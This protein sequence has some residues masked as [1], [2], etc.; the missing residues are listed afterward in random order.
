MAIDKLKIANS[1]GARVIGRIPETGP[2]AFSAIRVLRLT[3]ELRERLRP[4]SEERKHLPADYR[5]ITLGQDPS[6]AKPPTLKMSP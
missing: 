6:P 3:A 5:G 2:G 4:G 1:M